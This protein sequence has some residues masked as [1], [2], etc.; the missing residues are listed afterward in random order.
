MPIGSDPFLYSLNRRV[1]LLAGCPSHYTNGSFPIWKPAEFKPQ[2]F[3]YTIPTWMKTTKTQ[4]PSLGTFYFQ[5]KLRQT[6]GEN[7]K[8][9]LRILPVPE[10]AHPIICITA[11][12]RLSFQV[13][14]H[15]LLKPKVKGI[16]QVHIRQYG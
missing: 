1:L 6:L 2:E 4:N 3:K 15:H 14:F 16:M 9:F 10:G 11:Y 7:L 12:D 5:M 8:E 13:E